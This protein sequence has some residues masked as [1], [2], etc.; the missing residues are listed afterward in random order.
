MDNLSF[1]EDIC[2]C[3][4]CNG[5]IYEVKEGDTIYNISRRYGVT[6]NDI[7]N[8]NRFV[9]IY[10]LQIGDKLCIPVMDD[11]NMQPVRPIPPRPMPPRPERPPRPFPDRN[12]VIMPR[13]GEI[14]GM[15]I[16][17]E[18]DGAFELNEI[19][20]DDIIETGRNMMKPEPCY[21]CKNCRFD[22]KTKMSDICS[23][24][25]MTF[26]EFVNCFKMFDK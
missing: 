22:G 15:E 7:L 14:N 26:E 13:E 1:G 12:P 21:E 8:N 3:R 17:Y 20:S 5:T 16:D 18:S 24:P 9:N 25:D 23:D 6:V 2:Y 11:E 4:K 19:D 10:N